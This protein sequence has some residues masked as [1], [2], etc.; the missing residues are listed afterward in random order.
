M[1][2]KVISTGIRFSTLP[3]KYIRPESE[4]P[5]LSEVAVCNDVPVIDLGCGDRNLV[6]KQ[7]AE[8]CREFG[9]FQVN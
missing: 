9:F 1:E 2:A 5:R 3:D 8:A 4:R 6:V 7:I